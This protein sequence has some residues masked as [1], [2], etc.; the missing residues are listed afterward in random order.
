M[1][2]RWLAA[3]TLLL[4]ALAAGCQRESKGIYLEISG[5]IFV[6]N[7]R[8][9]TANYLVTL[10]R[11]APIPEGSRVQ[12]EFEDPR[13]GAPLVASEPLFAIDDRVSLTSPFLSC[14]RKDRP[15][16]VHVR[17]V[18]STG[19]LLQEIETSVTSDVDQ[20]VM[21]GKPLVVG[22]VYTPNPDVFK[23]DGSMDDR[24]TESCSQ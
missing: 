1:R 12:A 24:R 23:P 14:V 19:A 9:A 20:S 16:K 4:L 5:R 22:P 3:M 8:V 17:L 18:D 7:Y 21:P 2:R 13:G 11:V 6:F 10:R 15:Y